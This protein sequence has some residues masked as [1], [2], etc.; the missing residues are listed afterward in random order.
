MRTDKLNR[1]YNLESR[2]L[3]TRLD[4]FLLLSW[5]V[6][7]MMLRFANLAD[8]PASSIEIATL[9]FSLGHGF[10]QIPLN[11]LIAAS[12][13]LSPLQVDF[14]INA[15]DVIDRL[16][17]ESTH[18]PLY[19]CLTHWW[20][21]LFSDNGE[22]VSL[23]VGRSLSAILGG[24][25]IPAIFG[26]SWLAFRDR[27]TAHLTAIL[28]AVSPYGIYLAQEARHYTLS[29]LWI[30]ASISCAI[31]AI[32]H[33][34]NRRKLS[35]WIC[36]IWILING[37]GMAT[38]YFFSLALALEGFVIVGFWFWQRSQKENQL[39][40]QSSFNYWLP[41]IIAGLGTLAGCLV[42]LPVVSG[43]SGNELTDWIATSYDL[44]EIWQPIPRML[45]WLI[46]MVVLLPIEGTTLGIKIA[47][48]L[49]VLICL[50]LTVPK[51]IKN[52]KLLL[53]NPKNLAMKL[54]MGYYLGAVI[55]YLLLI[56]GYGKDVSLA[57]RYH[58]AYFPI[59]L[60]ILAAIL[61]R[62]WEQVENQKIVII[63]LVMGLLGSLTVVNNLGFQKSRSSNSLA[64]H[65][66]TVT[67]IPS[68][69]ATTYETHSQLRELIALALAWETNPQSDRSIT[70]QFLLVK[71]DRDHNPNLD[72]IL[73]SQ[74]KPLDLW[75]INLRT[76]KDYLSQINCIDDR[77]LRLDNSG[78]QNRLYHCTN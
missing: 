32:E 38:H 24:L 54:F 53:D 50:I 59:F 46:T 58:F 52:G 76:D 77:N 40:N 9:G 67:T 51:L 3:L 74:P 45:A 17:A 19:F 15:A 13:L 28:M 39:R 56:Y 31:V 8:K 30:I 23:Q 7:G 47:S 27:L 2:N 20:I 64:E 60:V 11:Q 42:W 1:N 33:I 62:L 5:L 72:K 65:I 22:L 73:S 41:I 61:A 71:R 37:L 78:Y 70:P 69:V 18:P 14:T 16:L 63:I 6:V 49:I 75:A 68:I 25:A 43:I 35:W 55:L 26:L 44:D 48:A 21:K 36:S 10:S 4:L 12:T 34:H 66:Q 57:A 29:I